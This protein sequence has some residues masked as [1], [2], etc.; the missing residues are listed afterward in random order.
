VLEPAARLLVRD[1]ATVARLIGQDQ[2]RQPLNRNRC[3]DFLNIFSKKFGE[4][5]WRF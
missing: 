2:R 1:L 3:Y 4:K 5:N